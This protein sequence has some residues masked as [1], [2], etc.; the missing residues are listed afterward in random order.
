M[1]SV[2]TTN[3]AL[4]PQ[5]VVVVEMAQKGRLFRVLVIAILF[6]TLAFS[7]M[8]PKDNILSKTWIAGL[9]VVGVGGAIYMAQIRQRATKP[10][11]VKPIER[12]ITVSEKGIKI[13]SSQGNADLDRQHLR[14]LPGQPEDFLFLYGKQALLIPK[15]AFA[16]DQEYTKARDIVDAWRA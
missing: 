4:T 7:M 16:S 10:G 15:R 2:T 14:R 9:L 1:P 11:N 13:S 3:F 12:K 8:Q 6:G 5:E